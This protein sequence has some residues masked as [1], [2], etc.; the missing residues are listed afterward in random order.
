MH[1][2][3]AYSNFSVIKKR[4]KGFTTVSEI[5]AIRLKTVKGLIQYTLKIGEPT[6]ER[7]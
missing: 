2:Y 5:A 6:V 3:L 7:V 1:T 4:V